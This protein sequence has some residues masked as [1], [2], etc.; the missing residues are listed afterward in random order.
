MMK[1]RHRSGGMIALTVLLFA[2][3]FAL[4]AVS[5]YT[6]ANKV[7]AQDDDDNAYIEFTGEITAITDTFIVVNGLSVQLEQA[8][9]EVELALGLTVKVEGI[10]QPD[11]V[12]IALEIEHPDD[13]DDDGMPPPQ[14]TPEVTPEVTPEITPE[15]TVE[16][17]DD[18]DDGGVV[19]VIRGPVQEININIITIYDIDIVVDPDDPILTII[20]IGD[21][22][23]IEGVFDDD[24]DFDFDDDDDDGDINIVIIAIN[25]TIINVEVY[26]NDDGQAWRD[27]GNC[28]NG[29]P[30]WAPAHG[31]RRRCESPGGRGGGG[32]RSGG[33]GSGSGSGSGS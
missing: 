22:V 3:V 18:D 15:A 12:I 4:V 19:I 28:Q 6:P 29:P 7:L 31:W 5:A 17:G 24:P 26:I 27:P 10:L 2:A 9:I 8:E 11:A 13:D 16:P 33:G 23:R 1:V 21:E 14:T 20:N 25:I 30:P 32:G